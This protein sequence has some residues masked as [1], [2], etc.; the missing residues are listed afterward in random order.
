VALDVDVDEIVLDSPQLCMGDPPTTR[1]HLELEL[2]S[3][4]SATPLCLLVP[5]PQG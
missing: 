5:G 3:A 1:L 4:S 2:K